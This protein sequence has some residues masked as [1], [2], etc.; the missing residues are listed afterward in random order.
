[1]PPDVSTDVLSQDDRNRFEAIVMPHL[2]AAYNLARWL[3]AGRS[4]AE[5]V[6]QDAMLRAYRFF[7]TFHSGDVRAWLLQIVR[8]CCYTWLQKNRN[9]VDVDELDD[10]SVPREKDTPETLAISVNDREQLTRALEQLSPHFREILVLRELEGC[11]YKEI[12]AIT[13]RPMGTIMSALARARQQ[14][15]VLLTK[16][17]PKE[18]RLEL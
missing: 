6:T 9:W 13:S 15:R 17:A 11:S 14:L 18:A 2:D 3:L 5:D 12:A 4:E 8:N 10:A 16:P 1:M 7:N